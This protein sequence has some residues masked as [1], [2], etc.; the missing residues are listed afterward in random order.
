[1]K[2]SFGCVDFLLL[3]LT[4]S[5]WGAIFF[6]LASWKTSLQGRPTSVHCLCHGVT[7]QCSKELQVYVQQVT[8]Y[9]VRNDGWNRSSR[10]ILTSR[11]KNLQV[12]NDTDRSTITCL[13]VCLQTTCD[14]SRKIMMNGHWKR[15]HV[16]AYKVWQ[17]EKGQQLAS[18]S[19]LLMNSTAE[20]HSVYFRFF[21][22]R[23][24]SFLQIMVLRD[25]VKLCTQIRTSKYTASHAK[26][27]NLNIQIL[28]FLLTMTFI[29]ATYFSELWYGDAFQFWCS[30]SAVL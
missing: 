17:R 27:H 3:H 23:Y 18:F 5:K 25:A 22:H 21:F 20:T 2:L 29:G 11:Q 16:S 28:P 30:N 26:D 8:Q 24:P 19:N 10:T 13:S 14:S 4:K 15:W 1:M 7:G 12:S 9:E 6:F